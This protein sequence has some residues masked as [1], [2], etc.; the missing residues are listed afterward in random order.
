VVLYV[1]LYPDACLVG[2]PVVLTQ[3][4]A[5]LNV[6]LGS[7]EYSNLSFGGATLQ[8]DCQWHVRPSS[9]QTNIMLQFTSFSI[10]SAGIGPLHTAFSS[11]KQTACTESFVEVR[12]GK[13]AVISGFN[14]QKRLKPE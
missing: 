1:L 8:Y 7:K 4:R 14:K 11:L 10:P 6:N 9:D 5:E 12:V 13:N 2:R 3:D